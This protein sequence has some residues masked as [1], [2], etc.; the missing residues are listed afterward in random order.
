MMTYILGINAGTYTYH[1]AAACATNSQGEVLAFIDRTTRPQQLTRSDNEF[2]AAVLDEL[3]QCGHPPVLLDTAD[4]A[5]ACTRR[6]EA[7]A[8]VISDLLVQLS[9]AAG[10]IVDVAAS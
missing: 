1:D 2:V 6:L 3:M 9:I 10:S 4:Q 8:V 7:D 5:L